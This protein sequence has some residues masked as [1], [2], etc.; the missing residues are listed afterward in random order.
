MLSQ[1]GVRSQPRFA[2]GG[3]WSNMRGE[4]DR[5][6]GDEGEQ[7]EFEAALQ[8][9]IEPAVVMIDPASRGDL[10]QILAIYNEVIR[11]ST[12]VFS[13]EEF[14]PS[15]GETWFDAKMRTRL[16]PNRR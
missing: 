2:S 8:N 9:S 7:H 12:A 5:P 1:T 3:H 16:S 10:P 11:N 15:R 4:L 13:D 6:A 14:T